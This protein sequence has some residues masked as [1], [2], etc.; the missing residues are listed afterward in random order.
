MYYYVFK[1]GNINVVKMTKALIYTHSKSLKDSGRSTCIKR[2]RAND[3]LA[4]NDK[5]LSQ[6]NTCQ[7]GPTR[8]HFR[9]F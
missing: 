5:F 2:H 9:L 3:P 8:L 4:L 6:S 1:F 7:E